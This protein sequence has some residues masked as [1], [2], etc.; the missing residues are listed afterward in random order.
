MRTLLA[1]L[2]LSL[3]LPV[4]AGDIDEA[5]ALAALERSDTVLIDVRTPDE[6]AEGAISGAKFIEYDK[7]DAHIT[8]VAPNKDT[9]IVLYCKSGRRAGIAQDTL[10]SLGYRQVINGGGY[11]DLKTAL[12]KD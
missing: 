9:P 8:E 2:A 4:L 11:D 1:I 12:E 5:A 6:I 3:S 10:Q 7:I